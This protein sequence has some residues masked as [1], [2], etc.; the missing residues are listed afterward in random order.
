M[1]NDFDDFKL[2]SVN[3]SFFIFFFSFRFSFNWKFHDSNST[4]KKMINHDFRV[5][6]HLCDTYCNLSSIDHFKFIDVTKLIKTLL[7]HLP[8]LFTCSHPTSP[9]T[10]QSNLVKSHLM[11]LS[12]SIISIDCSSSHLP[13]QQS[14][15]KFT[16]R[17]P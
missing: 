5:N 4:D 6:A 3:L 1:Q 2:T 17:C 9:G 14:L 16:F 10:D 12:S 15:S 13:K 11:P 8:S 7:L